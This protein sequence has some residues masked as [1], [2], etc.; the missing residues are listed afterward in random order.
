[1]TDT[2]TGLLAPPSQN[3]TWPVCC[4]LVLPCARCQGSTNGVWGKRSLWSHGGKIQKAWNIYSCVLSL[5]VH[6]MDKL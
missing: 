3:H 2:I 4:W 6:I 5:Q 1:M